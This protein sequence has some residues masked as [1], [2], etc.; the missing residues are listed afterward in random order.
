MRRKNSARKR[1]LL[2][3]DLFSGCGGLTTGLKRAGFS[4]LA[5]VEINDLASNTYKKNHPG[6]RVWDRDI[7]RVS[8]SELA[9]QAHLLRGRLDLLAGCPPCQ[10]F[11]RMRTLNRAKRVRDPQQKDLLRQVLRFVRVLRPKAVMVEN[12]P[13][14]VRDHRWHQFVAGLRKLNYECKYDTLNC[15]DFSVPQRRRRLIL[16]GSRFGAVPFASPTDKFKTVRQAIRLLKTAGKSGDPLHDMP[17]N[18]SRRITRLVSMIPKNGGSRLDLGSRRQLKCHRRCNGF[19][20]VYGRMS[21]DKVAPTIT[22]GCFNPS[23]GRFLH[24]QANRSITLREAALLQSFPNDYFFDLSGGKCA[25]AAMIGNALPPEF[26]R[27]HAVMVRKHLASRGNS[28]R[29]V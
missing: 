15:A 4:V 23:K 5:A 1:G 26:V 14:L 19:K 12:V 27:R 3:V 2:A 13:G 25:T 21:W 18:R 16:M 24:P 11:S 8:V 7:R 10:A 20:D 28:R 6:V 17:E 29:S 22:T 9:R